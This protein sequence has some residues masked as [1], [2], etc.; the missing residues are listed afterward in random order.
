MKK[1]V[2]TRLKF[3]IVRNNVLVVPVFEQKS[4]GNHAELGKTEL[5][6]ELELDFVHDE[7]KLY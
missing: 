1:I 2:C 5:F 6:I 4:L 3:D 7:K